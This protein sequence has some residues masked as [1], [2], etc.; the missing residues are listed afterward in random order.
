MSRFEPILKIADFWRFSRSR[1][2]PNNGDIRFSVLFSGSAQF[3]NHKN[4][5][6]PTT[7]REDYGF[8]GPSK[9][10]FSGFKVVVQEKSAKI[11]SWVLC[12][13]SGFSKGKMRN[14]KYFH[15][16]SVY[17]NNELNIK[18]S[19]S[20]LFGALKG[21]FWTVKKIFWLKT[22]ILAIFWRWWALRVKLRRLLAESNITLLFH[23]LIQHRKCYILA[24][25]HLCSYILPPSYHP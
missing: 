15:G 19:I 21:L 8:P 22:A 6:E 25:Q 11:D 20:L 9:V 5:A 3:F 12:S 13:K 7:S 10:R 23:P 4:C 16:Q 17:E 2:T 18:N 1:T 14:Q 24:V